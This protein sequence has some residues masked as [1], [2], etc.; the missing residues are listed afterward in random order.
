MPNWCNNHIR[1]RGTNQAEIQR[2]ADAIVKGEFCHSIIPTPEDL[3]REGSSTHG[4]PN[5]DLYDQIR[6]ENQA[7]HGYGNWYDFQTA[8]WGTKWDVGGPE[9]P[10]ERDEDGLGFSASFDSAWAPP[11]GI[12]EELTNRGLS[13][14][15]YYYEPGMGYVGKFEDG[16]D[17]CFDYSGLDSKTVRDAIGEELDDFWNISEQIAEYE[18]ENRDEVTEWYED[19]VEAKGLEPHK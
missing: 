2:L 11:M 8:R 7:K 18:A 9:F 5:A 12:V 1:V 10:V 6:A 13:V 14:T 19:G 15:L 3:L 4:G 17:E 16:Y